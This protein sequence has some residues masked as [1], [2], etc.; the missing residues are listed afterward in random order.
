MRLSCKKMQE[1]FTMIPQ[2]LLSKE[3]L[4]KYNT[5]RHANIM[6]GRNFT[7]VHQ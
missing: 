2:Q 6:E 7:R 5:N 3:D 1:Y 4:T